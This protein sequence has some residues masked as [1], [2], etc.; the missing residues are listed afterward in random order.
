MVGIKTSL[1][2][3]TNSS[4]TKHA[5]RPSRCLKRRTGINNRKNKTITITVEGNK[6]SLMKK[7]SYHRRQNTI[8][9]ELPKQN[10]ILQ[11]SNNGKVEKCNENKN[12]NKYDSILSPLKKKEKYRVLQ[13]ALNC[14]DVQENKKQIQHQHH[15]QDEVKVQQRNKVVSFAKYRKVIEIPNRYSYTSIEKS[16]IWNSKKSMYTMI[17]RNNLEQKWEYRQLNGDAL[18]EI[19]FSKLNNGTLIHP[20]HLLL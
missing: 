9:F 19:Y 2:N 17:K 6:L 7:V 5:T 1:K 4:S 14:I 18:E 8:V 15:I 10:N 13:T 3:T 12:K 20:A 16:Q 11:L